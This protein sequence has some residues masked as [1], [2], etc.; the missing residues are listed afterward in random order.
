MAK[1][2]SKSLVDS[3]MMKAE[4]VVGVNVPTVFG[5]CNMDGEVVRRR[6][7]K[8]ELLD[9]S[10]DV[11]VRIS[12]R[13]ELCLSDE[14]DQIYLY[15]G[16][17]SGKTRTKTSLLTEDIKAGERCV[18]LRETLVSLQGSVYQ[19]IVDE[20]D[21]R[22]IFNRG[23]E[24]FFN[25]FKSMI[26]NGSCIFM[27]MKAN[28]TGIK[29]LSSITRAWMEEI[30]DVSLISLTTL[31]PTILRNDG[32][33]IWGTFNPRNDDDP[34]YELLIK[35]YMNRMKSGIYDY[36]EDPTYKPKTD[37]LKKTHPDYHPGDPRMLIIKVNYNHNPWFNDLMDSERLT[38]M[39]RDHE[40]YLWIW[41]GEFYRNSNEQIMHG[42]W[43]V[44][45]FTPHH[46]WEDLFGADFGFSQD[47]NTLI[48]MWLCHSTETLYIEYE[49]YSQGVDL[50]ELG[51]FYAGKDGATMEQIKDYDLIYADK[52]PG[53]P[54]AMDARIWCDESRPDTISLLRNDK[55]FDAKGAPKGK[56]S[57]E[58][59]I[60]YLRGLRRIVIHPRCENVIIEAKNYKF[61]VDPKTER[62]TSVPVDDF[63]HAWDAIRY[64]LCKQIRA[65]R[66]IGG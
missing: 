56:G 51:M 34:S 15:G 7:R 58:D 31:F 14:F 1:K 28:I 22:G 21:R 36:R 11:D 47:P 37:R 27:G 39:E 18:V 62:I 65:T 59:G 44:E 45:E 12:E 42:K 54:G 38:M 13:V 4:A 63:N 33:Q 8:G 61:K 35:P 9:P 5:I 57:V 32:A 2:L 19:E 6:L 40:R 26:S 10:G 25:R 55:G 41:E 48:K 64:G 29:G 53:I 60:T 3:L 43:V 17:G 30:E 20:C 16:R 24:V 66:G 52:Y 50:L 23:I 46:R 49:A